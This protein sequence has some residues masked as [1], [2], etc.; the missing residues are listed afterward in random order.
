[1]VKIVGHRDP[2]NDANVTTKTRHEEVHRV[3]NAKYNPL[4]KHYENT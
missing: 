1:M 4:S 2:H 3:K